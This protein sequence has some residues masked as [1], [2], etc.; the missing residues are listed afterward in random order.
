[1]LSSVLAVGV[2]GAYEHVERYVK[3]VQMNNNEGN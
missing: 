3:N 1:M 2:L